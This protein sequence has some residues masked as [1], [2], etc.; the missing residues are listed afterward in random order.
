VLLPGD[1]LEGGEVLVGAD[2]RV[3]CAAC[4]CRSADPA[5][6][7]VT[8]EDVVISPGLINTH[9]HMGWMH[10]D[11]HVPSDPE[12]RYEHRHDWRRGKRGHPSISTTGGA[13]QDERRWG[14]LRFVLGGATSTNA[15]GR[16]AGLL[17]NLDGSGGLVDELG[18][19]EVDYDTFPLGD[20]DGTLLDEGCAYPSVSG[21]S[22]AEAWTP[23]VSEG[24]DVEAR[25]E[26]LCL[27]SE[28]DEGND[29]IGENTAI[30]HGIAVTARD[31]GV[32]AA[33]GT[34]LIWSPRS[35]L[36]LYGE[37]APVTLYDA[38]GVEIALGTDWMPSGSMNVLRE[39][40]C[41]DA[42][43]TAHLGG[44]FRDD[45]LW[46][47][48]TLGAAR[49]LEMDDAIGA[50]VP[51]HVADVALF[52]RRGRGPH[53]A[54]VEATSADVALVLRGGEVLAGDA[55]L[56]AALEAGCDLLDACGV[57]KRVC[58]DRELAMSFADLQASVGGL[59]ALT[60]CGVPLDEP[61]C[62]PRRTQSVDAI[63]DSTLYSGEPSGSDRDGDGIANDDDNC[64]G[65]FNP[66][67]PVDEG[68]Q[69]DEDADGTGDVCDPCPLDAFS[70]A[71]TPV[72]PDDRDGDGVANHL[73]NCPR[74]PNPAQL[75]GDGDG[76]GVECD[77]CDADY[78]PAPWGCSG[79]IYD[80]KTGA[81][82]PGSRLAIDDMVVTAVADDG[83]FA[84]LDPT[85]ATWA[86]HEH[87]AIYVYTP[88]AARPA[89]GDLLRID[90]ATIQEFRD[91]LQLVDVSWRVVGLAPPPPPRVLSPGELTAALA[92]GADSGLESLL[93]EVRDVSVTDT[94]APPVP[95][96]GDEG[97]DRNEFAVSGDLH[98][99]DA[100]FL[101]EPFV[102]LGESLAFVRGP[103]PWRDRLLKL[104]PRVAGD[105][106]FLDPEVLS[107]DRA[108]VFA[109]EGTSAG[110]LV[111]PLS[112]ALARAPAAAVSVDVT[113]S[114]DTVAYVVDDAIVAPAGS[115]AVD[116]P[117][118]ALAPGSAT[119]T[120]QTAGGAATTV[121]DVVVLATAAPATVVALQ[122]PRVVAELDEELP[123]TVVLDIPA[124][125]GGAT[126]ALS[127]NGVGSIPA[128]VDIAA[129]ALDATFPYLSGA[130]VGSAS[131]TA[132]LGDD[133]TLDIDV[134]EALRS[135][136]I[137]EVDYDQPSTDDAE[138]I[139]L[140]NA[141]PFDQDLSGWL[142]LL[143]NGNGGTIYET[144]AL[145][146]VGVLDSHAFLVVHSA[147][148]TPA[149]GA[150]SIAFD[151]ETN[152]VQN[153]G[154]DAIVLVDGVQIVDALSYEGSI[155]N[156]NLGAPY[157]VVTLPGN[158]AVA[159]GQTGS[160]QRVVDGIDTDDD[161]AD[162]HLADPATP[163]ASNVP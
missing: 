13:T 2:G 39:L 124:P 40:A 117:F 133:V 152:Q 86:G 119:L 32:L 17:R 21:G 114:D 49:A 103:L 105:L 145:G 45:E 134:I 38:M 5:A 66:I 137:N 1:V 136:V 98:V 96:G 110:A 88:G 94:D 69:R 28:Q 127:L 20:T 58:V 118:V 61:S 7:V 71:C 59:Y 12:L 56:V 89:R 4:D 163:G 52:H 128:T 31:V 116:V 60:S 147:N 64:P 131:V 90:G 14:E 121:V 158:S 159:D 15:S 18:E 44:W 91:Q 141:T 9:D 125:A 11:P 57:D 109:R 100:L 82:P 155:A 68:A 87:S 129:D 77:A 122:T 78:N 123:I 102:R 67:R 41:A 37:T 50:L 26:L 138:F 81:L 157:G 120:A 48:A 75:D 104:L 126:A 62:T 142:L 8:C 53:R 101:V 54:I 143:V 148:V 132:T 93:V 144:I 112:L 153:G 84:Q 162:W 51:G 19:P 27:S 29:V 25:N 72:D 73:D 30:V 42:F 99:D 151:G 76:V 154:P 63:A 160:L 70:S 130:V 97:S 35:N 92:D 106:S 79:S 115:A 161:L 111:A 108:Q 55:E 22:D 10:N 43:N 149:P 23:H 139:E 24:I 47:M 65:V 34:K 113:T 36:S 146:D 74:E 6:T 85:A 150:A 33:R 46:R 95:G 16:V 107:F 140:Y 83:F 135:V 3:A 80:V 156:A